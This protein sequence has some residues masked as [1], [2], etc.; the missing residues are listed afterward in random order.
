[1]LFCFGEDKRQSEPGVPEWHVTC[2]VERHNYA[3]YDACGMT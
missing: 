3:K 1:M 2:R